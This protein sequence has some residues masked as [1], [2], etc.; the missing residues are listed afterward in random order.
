MP[1]IA[2]LSSLSHLSCGTFAKQTQPNTLRKD[3]EG[4]YPYQASKG[5]FIF[6]SLRRKSVLKKDCCVCRFCPKMFRDLLLMQ[7][8]SSHLHYISISPFTNSILLWCIW[9]CELMFNS[10]FF[11]K[12]IELC[13]S[14]LLAIIR[15]QKLNLVTAL[16]FHHFF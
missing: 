14:I 2:F 1:E 4:L 11:T 9:C 3:S 7:H 12:Q 16:I 5:V 6:Q 15:P 13:C 8:T 10:S